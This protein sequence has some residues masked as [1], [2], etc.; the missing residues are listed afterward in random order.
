MNGDPHTTASGHIDLLRSY[1]AV[2]NKSKGLFNAL[3]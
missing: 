1:L 2:R 3:N